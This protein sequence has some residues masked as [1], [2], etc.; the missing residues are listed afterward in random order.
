MGLFSWRK[1]HER[2]EWNP[3]SSFHSRLGF[4]GD[5]DRTQGLRMNLFVN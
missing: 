4:V 5:S 2:H 3:V 1:H